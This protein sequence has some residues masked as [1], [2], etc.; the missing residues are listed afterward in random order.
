V[1]ISN[2]IN[3]LII[4]PHDDQVPVGLIAQLLEHWTSI[5]EVRV[6]VQFR[7]EFL[8]PIFLYCLSSV[9]N[10]KDHYQWNSFHMLFKWVFIN[11][12]TVFLYP[13]FWPLTLDPLTPWPI[14]PLYQ[15]HHMKWNCIKRM[16]IWDLKKWKKLWW[17]YERKQVT[18]VSTIC[19]VNIVENCRKRQQCNPHIANTLQPMQ[20]KQ[21]KFYALTVAGN[22]FP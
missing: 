12:I 8:R 13:S 6:W 5:A 4:D 1:D 2:Q 3:G 16:A 15:W 19:M 18:N 14:L 22:L 7:I 20:V 21:W 17:K 11:L 10:R 9:A